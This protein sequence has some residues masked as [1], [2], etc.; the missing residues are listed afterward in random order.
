M[1]FHC[2]MVLS[3]PLMGGLSEAELTRRVLHSSRGWSWYEG[4]IYHPTLVRICLQE[5]R[6]EG[7]GSW[8]SSLDMGPKYPGLR[9]LCFWNSFSF[10][11][12][13]LLLSVHC[14]VTWKRSPQL[15]ST[16]D[17]NEQRG[18]SESR[19]LYHQ[20]WQVSHTLSYHWFKQRHVGDN[21]TR[22]NKP[23]M[24]DEGPCLVT[25]QSYLTRLYC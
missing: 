4:Y 24:A 5:A 10:S 16:P 21:W 3:G 18:D 14:T 15:S 6:A 7:K 8:V 9:C 13:L 19:C 22:S 2:S 12:T 11:I 23:E 1:T 17:Q 25:Y 20:C